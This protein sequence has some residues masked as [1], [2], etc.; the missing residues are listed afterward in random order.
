MWLMLQ[1]DQ[2]D[3]YVVATG[4]THSV[5]DFARLAFECVDLDYRE[6]VEIDQ[7]LFRPAEVH[8]LLGDCN[9]AR[10]VLNWSYPLKFEEL[11]R[12]MVVEKDLEYF[13]SAAPAAKAA[14]L[15]PAYQPPAGPSWCYA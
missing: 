15:V 7:N 10:K 4:E 1:Q 6:H 9:K 11:V 12:H 5:E 8:L 2:P 14:M 3:D 13:S